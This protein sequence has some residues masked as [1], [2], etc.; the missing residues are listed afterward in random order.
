MKTL[1]KTLILSLSLLAAAPAFADPQYNYHDVDTRLL[2]IAKNLAND[3]SM[4]RFID[5]GRLNEK[6]IYY[7]AQTIIAGK[8]GKQGHVMTAALVILTI[9]FVPDLNGRFLPFGNNLYFHQRPNKTGTTRSLYYGHGDKGIPVIQLSESGE[10][11]MALRILD[12]ESVEDP[13][14]RKAIQD[15]FE[16][17]W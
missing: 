4:A 13:A 12:P 9:G 14:S 2:L 11:V 15:L 5:N 6:G 17:E 8:H 1:A 10:G 16:G 7:L 3:V